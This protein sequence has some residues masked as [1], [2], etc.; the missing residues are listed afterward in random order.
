MKYVSIIYYMYLLYVSYIFVQEYVNALV[1]K[2]KMFFA[3][4]HKT[5]RSNNN[6]K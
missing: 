5:I 3:E 2:E 1:Q 4:L 6:A